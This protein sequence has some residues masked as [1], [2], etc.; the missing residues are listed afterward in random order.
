M[1]TN[2]ELERLS[3]QAQSAANRDGKPYAV[4]NLNRFGWLPVIR[5]A[6]SFEGEYRM[7]AGPFKPEGNYGGE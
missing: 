1:A 3:A 5:E 7:V 4:F 2:K 6:D